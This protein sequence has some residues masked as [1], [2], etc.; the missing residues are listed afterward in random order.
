MARRLDT[1]RF[2][3][4]AYLVLSALG[5]QG[6]SAVEHTVTSEAGFSPTVLTGSQEA[7]TK[8]V[9]KFT[10]A[11]V[12]CSSATF[13][14]TMEGAGAD[15]I[16][17]VPTYKECAAFPG[18]VAATV[19]NEGCAYTLDSDT[20]QSAHFPGQEHAPVTLDCGDT[21][22]IRITAAG[23]VIELETTHSTPAPNTI[24]NHNLEGVRY[25]VVEHE[26]KDALTVNWTLRTLKVT[27][28]FPNCVLLGL[29]NNGTHS[30]GTYEAASIISGY[31]D[32]GDAGGHS[33]EEGEQGNLG[34]TTP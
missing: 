1:L 3:L 4:L 7:G 12:K 5:A 34:L 22:M 29:G 25:S 11:E 17:L 14:G 33:F 31:E 10:N 19:H 28:T 27:S 20:T 18:S 13:A 9:F 8:D 30:N 32:I 6:A 26:G 23:C 16:R 15:H 2:A 24:V 21:G